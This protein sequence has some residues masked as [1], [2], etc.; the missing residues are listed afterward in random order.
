LHWTGSW[1]IPGM[2]GTQVA[3]ECCPQLEIHP[4]NYR[5]SQTV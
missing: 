5:A 3:D 2:H 4:I 1:P